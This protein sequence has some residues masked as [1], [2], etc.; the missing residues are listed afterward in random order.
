[1]LNFPESVEWDASTRT[2]LISSA[3]TGAI[4]RRSANGT[5][6]PFASAGL[7]SSKG[8]VIAKF[9]TTPALWVADT[10]TL[11]A[12]NLATGAE[13][14]AFVVPNSVEINDVAADS[15]AGVLYISDPAAGIFRAVVSVTGNTGQA[16]FT[17]IV[18][19]DA[20]NSPNGISFD[21]ARNRLIVVSFA[22]AVPARIHA[23]NL[24]ATPP[25]VETLATTAVGS[26]SLDG[27]ARDKQGRY[28]VSSWDAGSIIRYDSTF[29]SSTVL[30]SGF[31]GPA[32]IFFNAA[33]DTL[34]VPNF[35]R[36]TLDFIRI[37]P[38]TISSVQSNSSKEYALALAIA[39]NPAHGYSTLSF[40]L[41]Q[42]MNVSIS[43]INTLG[44]VI[45]TK[46]I[47]HQSAGDH[48]HL[49]DVRSLPSG[50]Y[51]CRIQAD[52]NVIVGTLNVIR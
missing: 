42:P 1:M 40:R 35:T 22:H 51:S 6:T 25:T 14:G 36:S 34:V 44:Q 47:G 52:N 11:R 24:Q 3:A 33:A 15:T 32:D 50:L 7:S 13:L 2:Y 37:S 48:Q 41:S 39:P 16:T 38:P 8:I 31:D 30:A 12:F 45:I 27:I 43:I 5:I 9:G 49:F 17:Q 28:Y 18:Q 46:D 4:V 19:P 23:V 21:R 26:G 20:I 29:T 10:K